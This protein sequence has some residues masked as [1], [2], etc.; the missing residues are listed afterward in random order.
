MDK[1][2]ILVEVEKV[3][4]ELLAI[5]ISKSVEE[6]I[7]IIEEK[8]LK[9]NE[10]LKVIDES[11]DENDLSEDDILR[12]LQK[13]SLIETKFAKIKLRISDYIEEIVSEK[14]LSSKKKKA[15]RGYLNVGRQNDGYFI[16]KKK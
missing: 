13:N 4:D 5:D 9:R 6:I 7:S 3:T 1:F 8:L 14:S 2:L 12:I 11:N 16:D 10:L 15:H